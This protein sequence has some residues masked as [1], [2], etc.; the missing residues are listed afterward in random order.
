MRKRMS[1]AVAV[2][3]LA[4]APATTLAGPPTGT[5]PTDP[6]FQG[7]SFCSLGAFFAHEAIDDLPEPGASDYAK[8][9]PDSIEFCTG[10]V[11]R[12]A[13]AAPVRTVDSPPS[14]PPQSCIDRSAEG[15][16][17]R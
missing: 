11:R 10:P 5:P 15:D 7:A 17:R 16:C 8:L 1:V 3:L 14:R 9:P 12:E 6:T 2:G 13:A 4:A